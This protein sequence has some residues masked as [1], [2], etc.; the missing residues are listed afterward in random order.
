MKVANITLGNLHIW[1][2]HI[3]SIRLTRKNKIVVRGTDGCTYVSEKSLNQKPSLEVL[4][5]WLFMF[6]QEEDLYYGAAIEKEALEIKGQN[7]EGD[8]QLRGML[9][10]IVGV[11]S[12]KEEKELHNKLAKSNLRDQLDLIT[13]INFEP[14]DS[15]S[16][17]SL[18]GIFLKLFPTGEVN[19]L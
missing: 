15:R 14:I 7:P 1:K 10:D 19:V 5:G 8:P 4:Y 9:L 17:A 18:N 11:Y 6:N 12:N 2:N 16:I 13:R 3:L